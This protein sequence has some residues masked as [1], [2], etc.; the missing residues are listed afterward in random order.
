MRRLESKLGESS[1]VAVGAV[2]LAAVSAA[3]AVSGC[4]TAQS[5][6]ETRTCLPDDGGA[7]GVAGDVDAGGRAPGSGASSGEGGTGGRGGSGATGGQAGTSGAAGDSSRDAAGASGQGGDGG[8]SQ[9]GAGSSGVECERDAECSDGWFCNGIELCDAGECVRATPPCEEVDAEGCTVACDE[10]DEACVV[11]A[12][13]H[14]GDGSPSA[15]C[16]A[17]PGDDCDD[18]NAAAHPLATEVCDGIDNDCD[19]L[20]DL[21]DGLEL[22][23]VTRDQGLA[24]RLDLAWS[25]ELFSFAMALARAEEVQY[26]SLNEEGTPGTFHLA[27]PDA[28]LSTPRLVWGGDRF[29]VLSRQAIC[30]NECFGAATLVELRADGEPLSSFTQ[31]DGAVSVHDMARSG[32][33]WVFAVTAAEDAYT[34]RLD[35][36][37]NTATLAARLNPIDATGATPKLAFDETRLAAAWR[38]PPGILKWSPLSTSL[39]PTRPRELSTTSNGAVALG[40]TRAG[41]AFAWSVTGGL[42]FQRSAAD[43]EV[44]CGPTSVPFGHPA[45][46]ARDVV[47]ADSAHGTLV[48]APD[49]ERRLL[50]LF[51]FDVACNL[52]DRTI[53]AEAEAIG[54][55]SIAV[56]GDAVAIGWSAARSSTGELAFQ[57]VL[58]GKLCE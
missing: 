1:F 8:A 18:E 23:G 35:H 2:L 6:A 24:E 15:A 10:S 29:G 45:L 43:G 28:Q 21:S 52:V 17:E 19:G 55:P 16:T 13:D 47:L 4:S 34:A 49:G 37:A 26:A 30:G 7:A 25:P 12:P 22:S 32:N 5:C 42:A 44:V 53:V 50:G 27:V 57:R 48:L 33:D 3:G 14:D 51:R 40:L 54:T 38:E 36:G 58:G 39:E 46:V 11:S 9:A 41:Y 20:S 31:A 56:G